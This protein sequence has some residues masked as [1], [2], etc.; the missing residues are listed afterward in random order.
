MVVIAASHEKGAV[1]YRTTVVIVALT[2]EL[3][4]SISGRLVGEG[5]VYHFAV[6][7]ICRCHVF[8]RQP[9]RFK[10]GY[11]LRRGGVR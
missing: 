11:L 10:Q 6:D 4:S 9:K 8:H 7:E 2:I 5:S 3:T 1:T